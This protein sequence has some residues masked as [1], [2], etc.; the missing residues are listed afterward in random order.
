MAELGVIFLTDLIT[1]LTPYKQV[2]LLIVVG[3]FVAGTAMSM[4]KIRWE[5][6]DAELLKF[7]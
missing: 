5:L 6:N 4:F 7:S 3:V 1:Q 2:G